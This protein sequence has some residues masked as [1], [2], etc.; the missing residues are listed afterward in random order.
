MFT[1]RRKDQLN[2]A[3]ASIREGECPFCKSVDVNEGHFENGLG[4]IYA[5]YRCEA[6]EQAWTVWYSLILDTVSME[7]APVYGAV[8]EVNRFDREWPQ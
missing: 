2:A 8:G 3:A 1:M 6:C 7:N 4:E 5:N